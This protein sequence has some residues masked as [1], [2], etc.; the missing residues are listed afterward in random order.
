LNL[1]V[2]TGFKASVIDLVKKSKF[3]FIL[4]TSY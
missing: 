4:T 3:P 1:E 2:D